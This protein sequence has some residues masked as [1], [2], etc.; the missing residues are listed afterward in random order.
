M[1]RCTWLTTLV[2][3]S[4][5]FSWTSNVCFYSWTPSQRWICSHEL[6]TDESGK[7]NGRFH[8]VML[9]SALMFRQTRTHIHSICERKK[10]KKK[11]ALWIY[12]TL[13][14]QKEHYWRRPICS[15]LPD[16]Q[17]SRRA[18]R[19]ERSCA[20]SVLRR[21]IP[22]GRTS[23]KHDILFFCL[24]EMACFCAWGMKHSNRKVLKWDSCLKIQDEIKQG[25]KGNN[26]GEQMGRWRARRIARK[27]CLM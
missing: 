18:G 4:N 12:L 8:D 11:D 22:A 17:Q 20:A 15:T 16:Y 25:R 14:G 21:S 6:R 5:D 1:D 9:W 19:C 26:G 13:T 27:T 10:K 3:A 24:S 7:F 23:V 2:W